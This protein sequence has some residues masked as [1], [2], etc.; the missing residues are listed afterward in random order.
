MPA[1]S[2][3][4][5]GY[6]AGLEIGRG[7]VAVGTS[8]DDGTRIWLG[9][10]GGPARVV[11]AHAEDAGVGALSDDETLLAI[12]HSEHGDSRHR[13]SG[14]SAPR[15]AARSRRSPTAPGAA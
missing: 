3:V 2:G 14:S 5:D 6:P 8:T 10:R 11:Y 7:L 12:S 13:R 15:T 9:E 4:E 1:L